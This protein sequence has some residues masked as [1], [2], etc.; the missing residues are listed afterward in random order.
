MKKLIGF[1]IVA[2]IMACN[3]LSQIPTQYLPADTNCQAVLPNYLDYITVQ[4]NCSDIPPTQ[5]PLPGTILNADNP[6]VTV[7]ITATNIGGLQ[8]VEEFQVRLT[9][10]EPPEIIWDSIPGDT[11]AYIRNDIDRLI[12]AHEEYRAHLGD[13]DNTD[14]I[15]WK[16]L[17]IHYSPPK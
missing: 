4:N 5:Y 7:I 17:I 9:V 11:I 12:D 2:G 13:M 6:W 10:K 16:K 15:T 14:T 8:D 1:L 3:C